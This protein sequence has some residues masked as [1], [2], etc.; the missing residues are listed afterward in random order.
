M[1]THKRLQGHQILD[2]KYGKWMGDNNGMHI[3][4]AEGSRRE[5]NRKHPVV[6]RKKDIIIWS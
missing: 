3:N 4:T 2:L 6:N 1:K 5:S